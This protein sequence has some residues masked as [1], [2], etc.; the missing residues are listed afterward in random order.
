MNEEN[1]NEDLLTTLAH[2]TDEDKAAKLVA[3][4]NQQNAENNE[5]ILDFLNNMEG[6]RKIK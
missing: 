2:E 5:L 4:I 6:F 1:Q 3:L